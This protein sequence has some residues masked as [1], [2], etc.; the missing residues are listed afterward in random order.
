MNGKKQEGAQH[1]LSD[2]ELPSFYLLASSA[3]Q[4]QGCPGVSGLTGHTLVAVAG[5]QY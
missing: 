4:W 1:V 5:Q 3:A 2:Q